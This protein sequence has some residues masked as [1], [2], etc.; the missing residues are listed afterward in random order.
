MWYSEFQK[1]QNTGKNFRMANA[2]IHLTTKKNIQMK[3]K[4][5]MQ[6]VC[7]ELIEIIGFKM[8]IA[9]FSAEKIDERESWNVCVC[10]CFMF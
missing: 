7:G 1:I 5:A 6:Y 10:V 9:T 2:K 8:N 4:I 3:Q